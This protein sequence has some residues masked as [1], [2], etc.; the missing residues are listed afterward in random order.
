MVQQEVNRWQARAV[1]GGPECQGYRGVS[2]GQRVRFK[3]SHCS[4][5][6]EAMRRL[7]MA[8]WGKNV[9]GRGAA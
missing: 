2:V 7:A 3:G 8:I 6:L 5:D 4:E 1:L 9:Y